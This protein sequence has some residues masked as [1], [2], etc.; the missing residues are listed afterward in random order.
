[1]YVSPSHIVALMLV[2]ELLITLRVKVITESHPVEAVMVRTK[3]PGLL[4]T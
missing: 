3:V 4:K 2:V 1:M